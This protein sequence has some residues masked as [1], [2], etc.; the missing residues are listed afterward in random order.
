MKLFFSIFIIFVVSCASNPENNKSNKYLSAKDEESVEKILGQNISKSVDL[1]PIPNT[2]IEVPKKVYELPLPKQ[3]FSSEENNELRLH[4]LGE[5]RWIYLS[6]EPSKAWPMLQEYLNENSDLNISKAN[7]E[8]GE[9]F[10]KEI[11]RN[12][13]KNRFV[14]KVESGLQRESTEIF[15]S[16]EVLNGSAWRKNSEDDE[17]IKSVSTEILNGLSEMGSVTGTSLVALNLNSTNKTEVFVDKDGFSKIRLMV[18]FPRAWSAL[19]RTLTI[20]E[21]NIN[22][23]DREEGV[24]ITEIKSEEGFFGRGDTKEIKIFVEKIAQNETII[25]V[26]MEEQDKEIVQEIISQIN[27]VLS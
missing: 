15:I 8:T 22:D 5:I 3:Y 16:N 11:E 6:L 21:F 25:S 26:F 20:A 19:Q 27:Q 12:N 24:F 7:P 10:T 18:N 1:Y 23:F 13:L 4:K 17:Y 2:N 9:I 14:F